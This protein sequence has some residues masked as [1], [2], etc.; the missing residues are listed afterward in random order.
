MQN[1]SGNVL[2]GKHTSLGEKIAMGMRQASRQRLLS[3]VGMLALL[4]TSL[5]ACNGH[6]TLGNVTFGRRTPQPV[7][8]VANDHPVARNKAR[9]SQN[10]AG[11]TIN[12]VDGV[13]AISAS[14]QVPQVLG[15]ANS[16]SST[17]IGI[18]GIQSNTLI[19][20]GTDQLVQDGK[21]YYYAWV[22]MLPALPLPIKSIEVLQGDMVSF[23][24]NNTGKNQWQV[25][26]TNSTSGQHAT[27]NVSYASCACSA[28]WIEEAPNGKTKQSPLAQFTSVSFTGCTVVIH[29]QSQGLSR[30]H[31]EALRMVDL[32]DKPLVQPQIL[33]GN[34]FSVVDV[35]Q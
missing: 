8:T 16:D 23:S 27:Q 1:A 20:A 15:P 13:S 31:Y 2:G 9:S 22:E 24:I 19:Q 21:P 33:Q 35:E 30:T 14:W 34:D 28:E 26:V 11:Y 7:I 4:C 18:G 6:I 10:W 12:Q 5:T 3:V 29:G 17:W 25:T 32:L